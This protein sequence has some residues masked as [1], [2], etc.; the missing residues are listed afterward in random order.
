MAM[1]IT[2]TPYSVFEKISLDWAIAFNGTGEHI[3]KCQ[4][5]FSK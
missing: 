4:G 1:A 5:S 2:G 3:L